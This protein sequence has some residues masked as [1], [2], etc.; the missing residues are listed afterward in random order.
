MSHEITLS[1]ASRQADQLNALLMAMN[2]AV[3]ELDTVDMST[4]ITLALDL[5][6]DPA[7]WLLEEQS[8]READ[9]A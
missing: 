4:L 7:C 5:S 2:A 6:G 1:K 8:H 9:H 3:G